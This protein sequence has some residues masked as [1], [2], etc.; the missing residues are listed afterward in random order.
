MGTIATI[1]AGL[2]LA[3]GATA[4]VLAAQED[5]PSGQKVSNELQIDPQ[6]GQPLYDLGE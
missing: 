6:T 4:G 5:Q 2:V 1:L 3:G